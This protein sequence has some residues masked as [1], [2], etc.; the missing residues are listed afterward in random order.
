MNNGTTLRGEIALV[1]G[2]GRGIGRA[3]AERLARVGND[4]AIHDISN[5]AP[6]EFGEAKDLADVANQIAAH[7]VRTV[8]VMANIADE[9][10]V[11]AMVEKVESSLGPISILVNKIG[12][13]SCRAKG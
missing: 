9:S 2:S 1:T 7:G 6:A 11:R 8:A 4:V 5:A 3:I 13:A 10:Q 12:S